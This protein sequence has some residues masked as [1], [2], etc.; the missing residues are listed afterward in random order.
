MYNK[1]IITLTNRVA[2][3]SILVLIYWVFM[4]TCI[5]VFGFKVFREN[6]TE[7]F[8]LSVLAILAL[9]GGA[10]IVNVMLNLT[11]ISE[12][13]HA[14]SPASLTRPSPKTQQGKWGILIFVL[15]F[16]II[17]GLLYAGDLRTTRI[18]E[19][20]LVDAARYLVEEKHDLLTKFTP[21][22]FSAAYISSIDL[23][24]GILA[25]IDEHFPEVSV[26]VDDTIERER[27]FLRLRR[28]YGDI[29]NI[30][31]TDYIYPCSKEERIYLQQVL[32]GQE[33]VYLFSASDGFY[34]LY[35]PIEING[36]RLVLYFTDRQQYGKYGS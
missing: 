36:Q 27:V 34:E 16:P 9:L 1:K 17:F 28:H 31:K 3:M 29:E 6:I 19:R 20:L 25:H 30:K 24:L 14:A 10:I 13:L 32:D 21:Y 4:F 26:I 22:Q 7:A 8:Y 11:T 12:T 33:T 2:L 35:Y 5:T 15:S 23:T 18:R